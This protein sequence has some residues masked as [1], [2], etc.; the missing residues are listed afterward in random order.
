MSQLYEAYNDIVSF[1]P[2]NIY[3][4]NLT[5]NYIYAPL[6]FHRSIE[7]T[8]TLT[9][10]I[11]FN[12][13]SCNFDFKESDWLLINSCELHSCRYISPSDSFTGIRILFSLPFI[14][15]WLG[16][17]LFFYN[18]NND[19]LTEKIKKISIEIFNM[20]P[21][22]PTYQFLLMSK[23]YEILALLATSCIKKDTPYSAPSKQDVHLA[24]SFADYIENHYQE[25]LTLTDVADHFQYTAS[26]F[27]RHFKETLGVNFL[28]YLNFVR[29]SHAAEQLSSGQE[30]L[31][32]CAFRNGFPNIKSFITMFKKLYGCT[33]GVFLA[34]RK[35]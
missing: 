21:D 17:N 33:P 25:N 24:S 19:L 23:I 29:V 2:V 34:S 14:E 16:K 5:G 13:G 32:E 30:N 4:H 26:Y 11:R 12:S 35:H 20:D 28:S 7:L 18:P 27:S 1:L 3:R 31:T 15:K 22:A 9:G 10:S 8:V 6:H